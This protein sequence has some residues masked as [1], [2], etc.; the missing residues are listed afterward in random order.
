M[1]QKYRRLFL[2]PTGSRVQVNA[3]ISQYFAFPD[4]SC[5]L[6]WCICEKIRLSL[7]ALQRAYRGEKVILRIVCRAV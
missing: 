3:L 1:H 6:N 4:S 5:S 7:A 2:V